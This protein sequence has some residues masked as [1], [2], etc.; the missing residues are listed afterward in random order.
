MDVRYVAGL[1]NLPLDS[2][3][4]KKLHFQFE[5]TLKVVAKI[6][7]L[8]T[9]DV[10]PT[11]QVTGLS[12]VTREDQVDLTRTLPQSLVTSQALKTHQGY[13]VVP[14]VLDAQ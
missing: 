12:N 4:E 14:P 1:A 9:S 6:N 8:Q 10:E 13:F 7:E 11:Y 5:E 3:N 2:K